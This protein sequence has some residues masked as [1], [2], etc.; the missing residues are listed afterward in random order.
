MADPWQRHD[1]DEWTAEQMF[2]NANLD[3]I[4]IG[5]DGEAIGGALVV[6][7]GAGWHK[8]KGRRRRP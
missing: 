4:P 6:C 2:E 1:L 8:S 3:P 7:R 5:I